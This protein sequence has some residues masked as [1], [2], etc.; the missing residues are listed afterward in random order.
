MADCLVVAG[1][2]RATMACHCL[3]VRRRVTSGTRARRSAR[4]RL[5]ALSRLGFPASNPMFAVYDVGL[6][7]S[8]GLKWVADG[9]HWMAELGLIGKS[10]KAIDG[11][12]GL[13]V[14]L[15]LAGGT[16]ALVFTNLGTVMAAF[17]SPSTGNTTLN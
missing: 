15:A 5:M 13:I 7:L 3:G 10:E 12:L 8:T 17:A 6:F 16:I 14:V 1:V 11:M 2:Q 9:H 4:C